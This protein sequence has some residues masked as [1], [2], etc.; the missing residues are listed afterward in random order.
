M[1]LYEGRCH[2]GAVTARFLTQLAEGAIDVR[3]DQCSFCRRHGAKTVSDPAGKL[4]L[5]FREADVERYR[6]GTCQSDF[7]VCRTCGAYVAAIIEGFGVLNVVAADI[8]SLAS[9]EA[10]PVDYEDEAAATRL[11]RRRERWTPLVLEIAA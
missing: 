1:R 4:T 9:R 5:H 10:R 7:I 8:I 11:A 6:F 2:C 3:A